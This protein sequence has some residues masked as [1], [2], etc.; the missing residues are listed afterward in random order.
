LSFSFGREAYEKLDK[1]IANPAMNN[2]F[3]NTRRLNIALNWLAF[4]ITCYYPFFPFLLPV[5]DSDRHIS[6]LKCF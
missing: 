4:M 3:K 5:F 6:G 2:D 1:F